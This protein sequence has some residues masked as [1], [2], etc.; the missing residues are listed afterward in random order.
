MILCDRCIHEEVCDYEWSYD[1]DDRRALV[2]CKEFFDLIRCK[3][4][5]FCDEL[6]YGKDRTLCCTL[7]KYTSTNKEDYCSFGVRKNG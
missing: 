4:C 1:E 5:E 2:F 7:R 6:I 3:D